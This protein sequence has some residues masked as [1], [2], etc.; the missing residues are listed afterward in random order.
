MKK[1]KGP[2]QTILNGSPLNEAIL[3]RMNQLE[4][5]ILESHREQL[6]N[7]FK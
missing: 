7:A 3:I 5:Y 2:C 1:L 6:G 4:N